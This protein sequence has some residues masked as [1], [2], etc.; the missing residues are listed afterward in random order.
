MTSIAMY[1]AFG[2]NMQTELPLPELETADGVP[3]VFISRGSVPDVRG[4]ATAAAG[5][6]FRAEP[7]RFVLKV[8]GVAGYSVTKGCHI[9]VEAD[10]PDVPEEHIRLFLHGSVFAA[11]LHQRGY[12]V[13]HGSA[14]E[15]EGR[16]VIF[17]GLSGAGKSTTAAAFYRRGYAIVTDDVCAIRF[18]ADGAPEI[19]PGFPQ[20]KLWADSADKLQADKRTAVKVGMG[21]EK[22]GFKVG[23]G[24]CRRPLPLAQMFVLHPGET[25]DGAVRELNRLEKVAALIQHTYRLQFLDVHRGKPLHLRQCAALSRQIAVY[26]AIRPLHRF[27][28][29]ELVTLLEKEMKQSQT[30][31]AAAM[32]F[33]T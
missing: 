10:S 21:M 29:N 11:L 12:L 17:S 32:K 9:V 22:Y 18:R 27:A 26:Q 14:V 1:R 30:H 6:R 15:A 13:L 20:L 5:M 3:D 33:D 8:D 23:G 19:V 25:E 4:E 7:E 28:V 24:Y 31:P 2:L 16:A